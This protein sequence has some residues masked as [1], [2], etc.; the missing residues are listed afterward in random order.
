VFD[1]AYFGSSNGWRALFTSSCHD[2]DPLGSF[3][4]SC[5]MVSVRTVY[6]E[7]SWRCSIGF[8]YFEL[9]NDFRT[10]VLI[11]YKHA[12]LSAKKIEMKSEIKSTSSTCG[13]KEM[14]SR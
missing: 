7:L 10:Q 9:S 4:L 1:A 14:D 12:V 2:E 5:L 13:G 11:Y 8:L 3:I 6:L